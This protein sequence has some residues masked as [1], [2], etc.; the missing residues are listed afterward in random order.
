M[1]VY[2]CFDN[3]TAAVTY[4]EPLFL[5]QFEVIITP[6]SLIAGA[7]D[8]L[9]VEHVKKIS[10]LPELT[11]VGTVNQFYKF[12]KRTYATGAPKETTATLTI[13]FEVN[14]NEENDYYRC[15]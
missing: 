9:L 4:Y 7:T 13:D 11:G 2:V 12:A 15:L 5:N 6:P 3:S 10:G 1:C 14:L 8:G